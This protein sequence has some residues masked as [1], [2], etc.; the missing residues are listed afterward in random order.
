[1]EITIKMDTVKEGNERGDPIL[2]AKFTMVARCPET[3]KAVQINPLILETD[4][5]RKM[6]AMGAGL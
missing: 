6:F 1:M 4:E 3:N 2:I 5:D